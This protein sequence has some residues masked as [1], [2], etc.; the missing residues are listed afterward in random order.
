[1]SPLPAWSE[2][3][4]GALS[5]VSAFYCRHFIIIY[6]SLSL[7]N[8]KDAHF[9]NN[10]RDRFKQSWPKDREAHPPL[11]GNF[12]QREGG[13]A[14]EARSRGR[15][16]RRASS[17]C[18]SAPAEARL[19]TVQVSNPS[20]PLVPKELRKWGGAAHIPKGLPP[21]QTMCWGS[22]KRER[23]QDNLSSLSSPNEKLRSKVSSPTRHRSSFP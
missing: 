23:S 2:V 1:M 17:F 18:S 21:S 11:P 10:R 5:G 20:R 16:T 9:P 22:L 6:Q 4:F 8:L 3:I 12:R 19:L 13:R 15:G 7:G 14:V